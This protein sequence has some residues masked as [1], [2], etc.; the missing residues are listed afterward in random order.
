MAGF[1]SISG[2]LTVAF[3]KFSFFK[4]ICETLG[5]LG[6][7]LPGL[8]FA[9]AQMA[10][11]GAFSVSPSGAATYTIAIQV[12]PGTAGMQPNL[13]LT[14]NSHAGNGF[15]GIGWSLTGLSVITRCGGTIAQDGSRSGV[16]LS[17]NDKFCLDGQRLM[18]V[19]GA[20]GAAGTEYRTEIEGFAR[21]ISG[22][23]QGNG[24]SFFTVETKSGQK[25]TYQAVT[26]PGQST[27][28]LWAITLMTDKSNNCMTFAYGFGATNN[29]FYPATI[30]Y[31]GRYNG[32]TC[33]G[34]Y[35]SVLFAIDTTAR[36]DVETSYLLGGKIFQRQR[37]RTIRTLSPMP[38]GVTAAWVKEYRLDYGVGYSIASGRSRL[39][40]VEECEGVGGSC[41]PKTKFGWLDATP[42][43]LANFTSTPVT[44]SQV[45][46]TTRAMPIDANGDGKT[47][48]V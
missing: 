17:Y 22:G 44:V 36:A 6:I 30:N 32:S 43:L 38:V 8:S 39:Q 20:Y 7:L 2:R 34:T 37:L 1:R 31:S 35:N 11:P 5:M 13:A 23:T 29:E 16:N 40:S 46:P 26:L 12:P 9:Q 19:N 15:L 3:S 4:R 33:T 10:T 28:Y 48:I 47:D 21:I 27:P 41:L 24:P 42:E 45:D 14:Y 18:A 25:S